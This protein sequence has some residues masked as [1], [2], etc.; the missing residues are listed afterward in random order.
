MAAAELA[1]KKAIDYIEQSGLNFSIY[2]TPFSAQ[3]SLKKSF[4]NN[5]HKNVNGVVWT[6]ENTNQKLEDQVETLENRLQTSHSEN[7]K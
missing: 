2:L 4:A 7:S 1:F 3:L 5:F 6:E